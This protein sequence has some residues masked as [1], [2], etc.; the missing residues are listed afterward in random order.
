ME[1]T[2]IFFDDKRSP[3]EKWRATSKSLLSPEEEKKILALA[4]SGKL[5]EDDKDP[6][7]L[8][9]KYGVTKKDAPTGTQNDTQVGGYLMEKTLNERRRLNNE[10]GRVEAEKAE[11]LLQQEVYDELDQKIHSN[12]SY[13]AKMKDI[14]LFQAELEDIEKELVQVRERM[15]ALR[16]QQENLP[17]NTPEESRINLEKAFAET[18]S[19]ETELLTEREIA[20]REIRERESLI[21]KGVSKILNRVAPTPD[22]IEAN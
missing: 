13:N 6:L 4:N 19:I 10:Y 2:P 1:N 15:S 16:T 22:I 12:P 5:A 14:E 8:H 17:S 21:D 9:E 18:G 3:E 11:E 20:R 7:L